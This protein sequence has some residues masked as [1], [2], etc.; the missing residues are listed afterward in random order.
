MTKTQKMKQDVKLVAGEKGHDLTRFKKNSNQEWY[1]DCRTCNTVA[2]VVP[3]KNHL[4][5]AGGTA[6][7]LKCDRVVQ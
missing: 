7:I 1:A 2:F 5:I 4:V 6:I 3:L